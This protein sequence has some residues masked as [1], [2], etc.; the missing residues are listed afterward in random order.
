MKS[1]VEVFMFMLGML[2]AKAI[3]RSIVNIMMRNGCFSICVP[4]LSNMF[5]VV[6]HLNLCWNQ[7]IFFNSMV[8]IIYRQYINISIPNGSISKYINN[9]SDYIRNNG[10]NIQLSNKIR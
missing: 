2:I 10:Y 7:G 1:S 5:A 8:S 4:I 9:G 6:P 3:V